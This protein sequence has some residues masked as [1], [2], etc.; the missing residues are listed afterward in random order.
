M[1]ERERDSCFRLMVATPKLTFCIA[2]TNW[3]ALYTPV[4][5]SL[6][7]L[8]FISKTHFFIEATAIYGYAASI[9]G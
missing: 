9:D 1:K 5:L 2:E 8:S 4:P 3:P 7:S 6:H